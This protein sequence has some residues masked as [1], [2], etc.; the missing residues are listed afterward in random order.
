MRW[1]E[2]SSLPLAN[3]DLGNRN[4]LSHGTTASTVGTLE[5]FPLA[6]VA[7]ERNH[8]AIVMAGYFVVIRGP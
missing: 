1:N 2:R 5:P 6:V 7:T 4:V 3:A 8:E